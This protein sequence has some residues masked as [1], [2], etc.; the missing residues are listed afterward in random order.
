MDITAL[1]NGLLEFVFY[2][3][4]IM[5]FVWMTGA[6]YYFAYREHEARRPVHEPPDVPVTPGVS[7]LVPCHNE[8]PNV[9]ETIESL[10]DQDYPQFEI[11]AVNDASTDE[12]GLVL[13]ELARQ[14]ERIRVI[15]FEENQ[16]KAMG[17]RVAAVAARHE[18][19]VCIDGDSM[20]DPHATRW[21]AWHFVTSPRV[22]AVTGN[23]RVRNRST[24]L[25][26]IQVGE[27]SSIVG[28]IKRAQ[29]IYG[30][31][32]TVSGVVA[33]FR[34]SALHKVGYWGLDV[35]TE[36]IDVSWRLQLAH[37]D[38]R[39]ESNALC[40]ILSPE[41]LS[42]LWRQRLRWAR[43][44]MEVLHDHFPKLLRW[45]SRRMWIVALELI[46]STFWAYAMGTV[47]TLW[48]ASNFFTLPTPLQGAA[49]PPGWSGVLLGTTCLLQ[50]AIS[51]A[52]DSRYERGLGRVYYWIIW[53]PML[54]WTIQM[55]VSIV[56]MPR[57]F[58]RRRGRRAVWVSPDRGLRPVRGT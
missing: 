27:F 34:K 7:F 54:Y 18:I 16:G 20:L 58:L 29:R 13:D 56:A 21:L 48:I 25:G 42:G 50:F 37:W 15:H 47:A 17:L 36:D 31:V 28:T 51:L 22:A 14:H 4:M 2:Y 43:G 30:R 5:A 49:L 35:L 23:P 38:V 40:W 11:I 3:P 19:L 46:V 44:G 9:T 1:F 52:I 57:A 53:Y 8:G 24:L 45:R 39:Y 12:T 10:L 32:F 26:K 33:A 41:T 6:S 55:C